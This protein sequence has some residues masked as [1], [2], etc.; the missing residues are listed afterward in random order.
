MKNLKYLDYRMIDSETVKIARDKY[1]DSIIAQEEED[2]ISRSKR[3]EQQKKQ[4]VDAVYYKAHILGIDTM[5]DTM[6]NDDPDFQKLV[7]IAPAIIYE[8]RE[9]YRAKFDVIVQ[10]LKHFELKKSK[11]RLD[12]IAALKLGLAHVKGKSDKECKIKLE[13]FN[14]KRKEVSPDITPGFKNNHEFKKRKGS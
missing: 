4:E 1:M 11:E 8:M 7:P 3:L 9:D 13:Q 2:K 14:H 12:E 6:F 5:F 10:E